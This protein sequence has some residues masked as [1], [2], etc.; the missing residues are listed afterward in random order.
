MVGSQPREKVCETP[1]LKNL[2]TK[3]GLGEWL[4]V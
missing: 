1:I 2:I 3:K 4:K